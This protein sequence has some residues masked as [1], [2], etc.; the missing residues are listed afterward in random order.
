MKSLEEPNVKTFL[1]LISHQISNLLPTLRSRCLKIKLNKL[2]YSNFKNTIENSLDN[3]S[4]DDIKFFYDLTLGSPGTAITLLNDNILNLFELTINNLNNE[5]I[6][7]N[8]LKLCEILSKFDNEKFK[9]YLSI[10]KSIL[11][12]LN[13]I[14]SNSYNADNYIS[15][16]FKILKKVANSIPTKF[17]VDRFDFISRNEKEL[18]TYNLDKKIF[19]LKFL[20][21]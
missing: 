18:F 6:N 19:M 21:N 4:E 7:K 17:I 15:D 2:S 10:L 14:K 11:V 9:N 16:K 1:F 12:I 13:K 20:V 8:K 3:V 5:P